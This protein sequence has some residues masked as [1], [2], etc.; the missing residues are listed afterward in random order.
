M[1]DLLV[2]GKCFRNDIIFEAIVNP[3]KVLHIKR[4]EMAQEI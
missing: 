1:F 4:K 3:I 2:V